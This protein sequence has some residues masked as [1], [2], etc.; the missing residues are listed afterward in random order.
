MKVPTTRSLFAF[1]AIGLVLLAS[2]IPSATARE[3]APPGIADGP[4]IWANVW[5]YPAGDL[6]AYCINLRKHG[7]RNLFLQTTRINMP[8]IAHPKEL[9]DVIEACHRHKIRVIGWAYLELVDATVD[10]NKMIAA[11]RFQSPRGET[12]DAVAPDLEKNLTVAKVTKFSSTLRTAVG[13]HYPLIA[14]VYSPLNRYQEVAG[15][16]WK[17]LAH[18]YDVIAP[19]SYW[20][21]KYQK[22]LDPH[23]YTVAT[24]RSIRQLTGRPDIEIHVIGDGMGSNSAAIGQFLKACRKAEATSASIYPN[25]KPTADQLTGL[26]RYN[27]YFEPNSRF[28]LAAYKELMRSG[29]ADGDASVDVTKPI[30]RS[31]FYTMLSKHLRTPAP[32]P[33]GGDMDSPIYADEALAILAQIVD[34]HQVPHSKKKRADR[35]FAPPV[36]AENQPARSSS[37][38]PINLLDASQMVLQ[39]SSVIR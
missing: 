18:Y 8:A 35:W 19:M 26:A 30:S 36:M 23:D 1:M 17:V 32:A 21:S 37:D 24:V 2:L 14:C 20:N 29:A 31:T 33:H 22:Q 15:M 28:R 4:G 12:L 9:G 13:P 3:I 34:I 27:D 6:D 10:A 25:Q 38:K 11:A 5:N 16:P 39:V 7:V